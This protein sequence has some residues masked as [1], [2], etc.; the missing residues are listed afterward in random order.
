MVARIV[1]VLGFLVA[2][3]ADRFQP[4]PFRGAAGGRSE[5]LAH[6]TCWDRGTG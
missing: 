3:A 4:E 6:F 1:S 5:T 2:Q